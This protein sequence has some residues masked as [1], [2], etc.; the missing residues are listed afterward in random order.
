MTID[1][2][3]LKYPL[4]YM[5]LQVIIIAALVVLSNYCCAVELDGEK[6]AL[7]E[8]LALILDIKVTKEEE[9]PRSQKEPSWHISN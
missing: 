7:D 3:S 6:P 9:L 4:L 5:N 2:F 8:D 1:L